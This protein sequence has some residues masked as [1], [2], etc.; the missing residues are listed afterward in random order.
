MIA[1]VAIFSKK[2]DKSTAVSSDTYNRRGTAWFFADFVF[3]SQFYEHIF[4][5]FVLDKASF[6]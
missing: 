1:T 5:G 6:I 4:V 2:V 3:L